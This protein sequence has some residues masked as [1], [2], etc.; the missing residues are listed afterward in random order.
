[1]N[2]KALEACP[3]AA[4][5]LAYDNVFDI[6]HG[7]FL[8]RCLQSRQCRSYHAQAPL[9]FPVRS[10]ARIAEGVVEAPSPDDTVGTDARRDGE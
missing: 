5:L 10:A 9:L 8:D 7:G 6:K 4:R 3:A 2:G 1:M